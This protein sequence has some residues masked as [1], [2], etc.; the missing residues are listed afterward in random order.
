MFYY[1]FDFL[2]REFDLV[3]AGLFSFIT[4]RAAAAMF[5]SLLIS[6]TFGKRIID[7]L[8]SLQIGETVRDLGLE[9][10][11][12][13]AGTPTMGGSSSFLLF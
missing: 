3:G 12:E 9:G 2:D 11:N 4:F 7:K 6:I 10:Q 8:R 1:L 13:K 5:V